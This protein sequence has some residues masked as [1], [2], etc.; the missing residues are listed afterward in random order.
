MKFSEKK[1]LLGFIQATP[2][3]TKEELNSFYENKYFQNQKGSYQNNY[4]K[5]EIEYFYNVALVSEKICKSLQIE[6]SLLDIGCGEGFFSA[7]CLDLGW[8]I[9]CVDFSEYGIDKFNPHLKKYFKKSDIYDFIEQSIS[10]KENYGMINLQHVLEHVTDPISLLEQLKKILKKSHSVLRIKVPNDYSS[11]QKLLKES[12]FTENT[13]FVP[14]EHL[15]YFNNRNIIPLLDSCGFRVTKALG[16]FPIEIFITNEH[17]NYSKNKSLGKQAHVSRTLIE[18]FL[19]E[20]N[21]D[22]YISLSESLFQNGMCR[23]LTIFAQVR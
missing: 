13:W 22:H 19:I 2:T 18:N 6:T 15:N 23:N 11:F 17:S 4:S 9:K 8:S 14:P 12:N 7:K 5:N 21:I 20:E 1:N 16:D 3:P 10:N